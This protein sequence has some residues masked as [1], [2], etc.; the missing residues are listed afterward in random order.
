MPM[1][2]TRSVCCARAAS[3]HAAA[4]PMSVM[5]ARRLRSSMRLPRQEPTTI[6]YLTARWGAGFWRIIQTVH[7]TVICLHHDEIV[8]AFPATSTSA[9]S[10]A[11]P[12]AGLSSAE[13]HQLLRCWGF[14]A[15]VAH[16]P[17]EAPLVA[18]VL[19]PAGEVSDVALAAQQTRP[20]FRSLHHSIIEPHRE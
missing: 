11:S 10:P 20:A 14:N 18:V 7:T 4:P 16:Q 15:Q 5:N 12:R 2:R 8:A 6:I 3:G 17:V 19:L 1:R 13:T 9:L